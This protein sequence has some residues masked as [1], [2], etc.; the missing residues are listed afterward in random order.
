MRP[1][2][3]PKKKRKISEMTTQIEIKGG[4]E[5]KMRSGI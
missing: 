2:I 3:Q 5:S 1:V 4:R